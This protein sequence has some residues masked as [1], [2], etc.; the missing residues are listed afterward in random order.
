MN[1]GRENLLVPLKASRE[2]AYLCSGVAGNVVEECELSQS[3]A[4]AGIIIV[5]PRSKE[6]ACTAMYA[7]LSIMTMPKEKRCRRLKSGT[8]VACDCDE[9]QMRSVKLASVCFGLKTN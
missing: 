6:C 5:V 1:R 3:N 7:M 2:V 4:Q 9:D 8:D